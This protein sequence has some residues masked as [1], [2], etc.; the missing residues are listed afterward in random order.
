MS[1]PRRKPAAFDVDDPRLVIEADEPLRADTAAFDDSIQTGAVARLEPAPHSR[2]GVPWMA[3]F[4]SACSG[5]LLMVLVL[6][7]TRLVED[8]FARSAWLGAAGLGL[9][10]LA[11]LALA[12]SI[13]REAVALIRLN[14]VATLRRRALAVVESD[15]REQGR[16]LVADLIGQAR[17]IPQL[18]RARTRL[19]D[20]MT[21]IIDGRDLVRIAERELMGPL[22]AEARRLVAAA[23]KRVSVV[24]AV[25]PR[26][27]F[28]M[29]FV[30]INA[31]ALIRRLAGLYGSRPGKLGV[32]KLFRR[33]VTHLAV[34]GGIAVSDSV[35]QQVVGHGLAARLSA[36]LGEGM[37]NGLMTARLGLLAI[38][39]VRPLPFYDLPRPTLNDLAGQLLQSGETAR[40]L[41]KGAPR[42]PSA[43]A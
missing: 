42:K 26:A 28:D 10:V 37:L 1:D 36:R 18:A 38:D 21:D 29:L 30:L 41:D 43:A 24:T 25:S 7:I 33:V 34:T 5:L 15:D 2:R 3:L 11:G 32:L 20:H 17:R 16:A 23:G 9:A 22:D 8:L 6:G 19:A 39:L 27:A 12:V 31:L 4:W 14:G 35:L 40:D 13:V